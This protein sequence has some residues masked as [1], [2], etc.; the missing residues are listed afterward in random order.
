MY[1]EYSTRWKGDEIYRFLKHLIHHTKTG[2]SPVCRFGIYTVQQKSF[3]V[4]LVSKTESMPKNIIVLLAFI[5]VIKKEN[6]IG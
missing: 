6:N 4:W 2:V 1:S 5:P 3:R